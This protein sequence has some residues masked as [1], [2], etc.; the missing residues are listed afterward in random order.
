MKLI[1]IISKELKENVDSRETA[2]KIIAQIES[3]LKAKHGL[4]YITRFSVLAS[5]IDSAAG[6]SDEDFN[7]KKLIHVWSSVVTAYEVNEVMSE[8][9]SIYA[10]SKR[11]P[12]S[13]IEPTLDDDIYFIS[14]VI[15]GLTSAIK[16]KT[17]N[18]E[19]LEEAIAS[20]YPKD[21]PEAAPED[22]KGDPE[23][24]GE[25]EPNEPKEPEEPEDEPEAE[26]K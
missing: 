25:P 24:K 10:Q 17:Q 16:S 15:R 20:M 9:Q 7:L 19:S 11:L 3:S 8:V 21:E 6:I 4:S 23:P 14:A 18:L 26:S 22:P 13:G 12:N 2:A 5:C 1:D